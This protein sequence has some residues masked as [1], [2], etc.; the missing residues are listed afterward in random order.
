MY[1]KRPPQWYNV[2]HARFKLYLRGQ[3]FR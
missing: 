2:S 1:H 3:A